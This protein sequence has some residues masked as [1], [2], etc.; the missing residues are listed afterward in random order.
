MVLL[1]ARDA[2]GAPS[3]SDEKFQHAARALDLRLTL[4][5]LQAPPL[6]AN[7]SLQQT[8]LDAIV[9][10]ARRALDGQT[11]TAAGF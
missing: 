1:T 9:S 7:Y 2:V 11:T 8:D 6:F 10:A 3:A 5:T 4:L